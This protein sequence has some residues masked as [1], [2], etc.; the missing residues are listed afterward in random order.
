MIDGRHSQSGW[1]IVLSGTGGQGVLTAARLLCDCLAERGHNVV[2]GQLHGMAQR[3]GSVHSSVMI[4]S[5]ISP[6]MGTGRADYVLGLEPVETTRALP[7]MSSRTVV[8]M[9]T[10]PIIPFVIGQQTVLGDGEAKYPAVDQLVASIRAVTKQVFPLDATRLARECGSGRAVN[11]IMLGCLLGSEALPCTADDFWN[12]AA[13]RIPKGLVETNA[14][15]FM[16][17]AKAGR[18]LRFAAEGRV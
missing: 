12:S 11:M 5:G 14:R 18:R 1:R 9:N 2:S 13:G 7:L 6:V 3:G 4:D 15:A 16:S 8:Y 10:A 17:G